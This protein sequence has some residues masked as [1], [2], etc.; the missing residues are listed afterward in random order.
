MTLAILRSRLTYWQH[1]LN[2]PEWTIRVNWGSKREMGD[3]VGLCL[4][5][6]EEQAAIVKIL[7]GQPDTE[8]TLVH[9]LL[10][11]VLQGHDEL[12]DDY[13]VNLERA[14]NRIAHAL[15]APEGDID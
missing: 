8:E 12:K 11:I 7:R 14:I 9:E 10:H 4:W 3:S 15:C 2:L 5:H 6:T 13:S 1:R